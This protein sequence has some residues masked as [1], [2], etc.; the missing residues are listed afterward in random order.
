MLHEGQQVAVYEERHEAL[1]LHQAQADRKKA[2]PPGAAVLRD[3]QAVRDVAMLR[4]AREAFVREVLCEAVSSTRPRSSA[5][6]SC[7][8]KR[9]CATKPR[10]SARRPCPESP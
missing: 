7:R 3:A 5:R 10:S 2:V 1:V 6:W 8:S 9:P 4:E